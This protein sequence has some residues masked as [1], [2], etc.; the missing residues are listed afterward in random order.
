MSEK[1]Y[2]QRLDERYTQLDKEHQK[3]IPL[4]QQVRDYI[5]P[6]RG[7]FYND[8]DEDNIPNWN[9][10]HDSICTY[11]VRIL[12]SA[13][14]SGLAG[15][16]RKWFNLTHWNP[17]LIEDPENKQYV[18][19]CTNILYHTLGKTNFYPKLFLNY[20]DTI[21]YGNGCLS[22]EPSLKDVSLFRSFEMGTY[23]I[24]KDYEGNPNEFGRP[25]TMTVGQI[26]EK[27]VEKPSGDMDWRKASEHVKQLYEAGQHHVTFEVKQM[28]VPN[29][30]YHPY[31][32]GPYKK[33]YLSF[34]YENGKLSSSP[35]YN[36][37]TTFTDNTFLQVKGHDFF[38]VLFTQADPN[39]GKTYSINS[40]SITSLPDVKQLQDF[41]SDIMAQSEQLA[42]PTLQVPT[43]LE[44]QKVDLIAGDLI[45]S[46]YYQGM[47][48]IE[49]VLN[50]NLNFLGALKDLY[51]DIRRRVR[52][53]HFIDIVM[54]FHNIRKE[55]T[56]LTRLNGRTPTQ[57]SFLDP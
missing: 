51:Q 29:K 12:A 48:K 11:C 23:R 8:K 42:K 38:P 17:Q 9:L 22:V 34:Y 21:S 33:K 56:K 16:S 18:Y 52:D 24:G 40:P 39:E 55:M 49:P 50:P 53:N 5:I 54:P 14:M 37:K 36:A 20:L 15:P 26:V 6:Y 27:F 31:K 44:N 46:D 19:A 43:H 10:I 28:I 57:C 4:Y 13:F 35:S 41:N 1:T 45:Y 25:L 2:K 3:Y 32:R 47:N 30:D 7:Q